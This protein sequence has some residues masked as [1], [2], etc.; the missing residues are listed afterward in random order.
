MSYY[1]DAAPA[2]GSPTSARAGDANGTPN[3]YSA[4]IDLCASQ[5]LFTEIAGTNCKLV[6]E[7]NIYNL[8]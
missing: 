5:K 7:V 2:C 3:N 4:G 1:S 8:H 6:G